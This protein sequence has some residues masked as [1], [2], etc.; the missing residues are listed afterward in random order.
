MSFRHR[1]KHGNILLGRAIAAVTALVILGI[2]CLIY[3]QSVLTPFPIPGLQVTIVISAI[4]LIA[5]T[6]AV[7]MR[8]AWGRVMMLTILYTGAIGFFVIAVVILGA[9]DP[10]VM[11]RLKPLGLAI[12][13]YF[14]AVLVVSN[15]RHIRRLTSRSWE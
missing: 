11:A 5:G 4:W 1:Q 7:C 3:R 13:V 8:Q 10:G 14:V 15:S 12:F 6:V 2:D 9:A